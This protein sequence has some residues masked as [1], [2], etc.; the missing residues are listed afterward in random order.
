M[1]SVSMLECDHQRVP[2][3]LQSNPANNEGRT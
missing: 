3:G 2:L 1:K